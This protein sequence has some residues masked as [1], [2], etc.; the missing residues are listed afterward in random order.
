MGAVGMRLT[1]GSVLAMAVEPVDSLAGDPHG[2]PTRAH[3]VLTTARHRSGS[4]AAHASPAA[5]HRTR[6]W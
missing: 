1:G 6:R 2:I 3:A 4:R 5:R